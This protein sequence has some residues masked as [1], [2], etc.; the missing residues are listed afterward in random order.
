MPEYERWRKFFPYV[1]WSKDL[2]DIW[3][4]T[5]RL[6]SRIRFATAS[7]VK[8]YEDA[9][10][11]EISRL[12]S[13]LGSICSAIERARWIG[14]PVDIRD[15]RRAES[16]TWLEYYVS[17]GITFETLCTNISSVLEDAEDELEKKIIKRKLVVLHKRWFY[18]SA[19]G[20]GHDI[21]IELLSTIV[22]PWKEKKEDYKADLER[23]MK[24]KIL[25]YTGFERV[26][27]ELTQEVLGFEEVETDQAERGVR[28]EKIEWR[29]K[30]IGKQLDIRD[31]LR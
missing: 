29:H 16:R 19:R 22:I 20:R 31:F 7:E 8:K 26:E 21:E 18:E 28:V 9:Y 15:V 17:E 5:V 27:D 24:A 25:E 1:L 3:N 30:I 23:V 14:L 12:N 4:D 2:I 10:R 13:Y 11:G 6:K